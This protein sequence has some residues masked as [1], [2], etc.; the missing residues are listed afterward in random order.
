MR[1]SFALRAS[2]IVAALAFAVS[3]CGGDDEPEAS[4]V[5]A[6]AESFCTSVGDWR[7]TLEELRNEFTGDPG[8]F[9]N[10]DA[11]RDAAET[12]TDATDELVSDLRE[13]GAPETE[14][15]QAVESSLESLED[16][17]DT[18]KADVERAVEGISS[19][20]DVPAALTTVGTALTTMA[21][22]LQDTLDAIGNEDSAGELETA[23]EQTDACDD[24]TN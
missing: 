10:E 7:T 23:F 12:V 5:D 1:G 13:L 6:W 2:A 16:T 15:G 24:L 14:S 22:S 18:Q 19:L 17:I 9:A 3:A 21:T 11:L 4:S 20:A 8:S